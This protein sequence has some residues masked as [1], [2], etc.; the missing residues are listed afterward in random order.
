MK[1]IENIPPLPPRPA[2][3][4]KGMFGRV[5]VVGGNDQM[6]GAPALAG[7]AALRMGAGLVQVAVPQSILPAI[8]TITPELIGLALPKSASDSQLL[9]AAEKADALAIGPG[10]GQSP[11]AKRRVMKLL[12]LGKPMVLDADAL[13]ILA[14]GK[15]WPR[16]K[17]ACVLT[18][19][20]GEMSRLGRLF[21]RSKVPADDK[22]RIEIAIEASKTFGQIVVLKG[23]RTIVTDGNRIYVNPTGDS[24]LSKAG[25]G[26]ILSGMLATLLAQEMDRF[27]AACAAVWLHGRAGEIAA[28]KLGMRCVLAREVIEALPGA[29][30]EYHSPSVPRVT[31][32]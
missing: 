30:A 12:Q 32:N 25:T 24:S 4:H 22:G 11:A 23:S 26:D 2:E 6:I 20:P 31:P 18:P 8:L 10:M 16:S 14:A 13:N 9:D 7:T 29:I 3:G 5:L 28:K 1:R 19:H 21:G 15:K 17:A 27:D